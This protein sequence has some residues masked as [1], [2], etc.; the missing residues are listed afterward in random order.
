MIRLFFFSKL[1]EEVWFQSSKWTKTWDNQLLYSWENGFWCEVISYSKLWDAWEW[2]DSFCC[3]IAQHN[4]SIL[5]AFK[6]HKNLHTKVCMSTKTQQTRGF[7][8]SMIKN[9]KWKLK[10]S[11]IGSDGDGKGLLNSSNYLIIFKKSSHTASICT[12]NKM[13]P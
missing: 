8:L 13:P 10:D 9:W 7:N 6:T 2:C 5:S 12:F 4:I 1:V 3:L 11:Q